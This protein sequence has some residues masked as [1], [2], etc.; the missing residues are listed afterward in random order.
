M[1]WERDLLLLIRRFELCD[2]EEEEFDECF[3]FVYNALKK[4]KHA[5]ES[6]IYA[7]VE[8][9]RTARIFFGDEG[10]LREDPILGYRPVSSL[11]RDEFIQQQAKTYF[12]DSKWIEAPISARGSLRSIKHL[13]GF[14]PPDKKVC[15]YQPV[16]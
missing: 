14:Y 12:R 15:W 7:F 16:R 4:S 1:L 9:L 2:I 6:K 11:E 8:N 13:C 10:Y 5:D 3:R